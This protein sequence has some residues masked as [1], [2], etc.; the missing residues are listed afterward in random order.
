[1]LELMVSRCTPEEKG[2]GSSYAEVWVG[3]GSALD[4]LEK[5]RTERFALTGDPN[6]KLTSPSP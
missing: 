4:A 5:K 6:L 2:D 3:L 1:M